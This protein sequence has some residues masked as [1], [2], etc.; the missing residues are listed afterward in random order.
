MVKSSIK[1]GTLFGIPLR[2]HISW[3]LIFILITWSLAGAYFP[4]RYPH[5][6]PALW[7][8]VGLTT[9]LLFFTSVV[10]HEVAHS[11]VARSRG[12]PTGDI[13]LFIF[14][15][16][17][18]IT[19][20]PRS[21]GTEFLMAIAG[22]LTSLVL[23]AL[24]GILALITRQVSEPIAALSTYLAGINAMLSAFNLLPG[25]PLDG[26]RVFRAVLWAI[27]RDFRWATRWATLAGQG[28]AYIFITL[29]LWQVFRGNWTNGLWIA[30]IGWFLDNAAQTSYRQVAL[31]SLLAGHTVREV[32]TRE[33]HPLSPALTLEQLVHEHMLTTGR[34]CYPIMIEGQIGQ[35]QGLLTIHGVKQIPRQRWTTTTA[36]QAMIPLD[37][38]KT[39]SPDEGLWS[40]LQQMTE[41]G[42]NQLPVM[43]AGRLL[44][45]LARDN[46]LTFL[47]TRAELGIT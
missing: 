18:Q 41:E 7:W 11:L 42:V 24:F 2:V 16:A 44:G 31:Q 30:F 45:M 29:G 38:L 8:T 25:F 26:G 17:A 9:T 36:Q 19:E 22:P 13:T 20:E 14:G 1:I 10:V 46:V 33:C 5:W 32:M 35:I 23:S 12:L 39:I 3:F 27:R 28:L 34:R 40:A 37:K 21:A 6:Q 47:R 15:G 4:Q 43:E